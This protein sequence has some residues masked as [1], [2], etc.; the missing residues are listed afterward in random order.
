MPEQTKQ[1]SVNE[2]QIEAA[3]IQENEAL[4]HP[5]SVIKSTVKPE[6]QKMMQGTA[7]M[8]IAAQSIESIQDGNP[9]FYKAVRS[10]KVAQI[11]IVNHYLEKN[12]DFQQLDSEG[13]AKKWE[14]KERMVE[15]MMEFILDE[16]ESQDQDLKKKP[17]IVRISE[18]IDHAE[19]EKLFFR[20]TDE[21]IYGEFVNAVIATQKI[22]QI[23]EIKIG[24]ADI[25][26]SYNRQIKYNKVFEE[27]KHKAIPPQP[28]S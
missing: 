4:G 7:K 16:I 22:G 8:D 26:A 5:D 19:K 11:N 15:K 18:A 27:N 12:K 21:I 20:P 1:L 13:K 17:N 2:A 9:E 25:Q 23:G 6:F 14:E 3:L 10:R 24:P 28:L